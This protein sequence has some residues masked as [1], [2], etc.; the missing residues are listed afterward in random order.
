[1]F[2]PFC[3]PQGGSVLVLLP[4]ILYIVFMTVFFGI[5]LARVQDI[6]R[7]FVSKKNVFS[8]KSLPLEASTVCSA[9]K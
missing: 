2:Q 8:G 7:R 1:M 5:K 6:L 9:E 3:L 4:N